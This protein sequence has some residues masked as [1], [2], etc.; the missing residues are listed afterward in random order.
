MGAAEELLIIV[1]IVDAIVSAAL[2]DYKD[3]AAIAIIVA[4]NAIL[5]FSHE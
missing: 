5:G 1:L 3:A 4:L 2:A